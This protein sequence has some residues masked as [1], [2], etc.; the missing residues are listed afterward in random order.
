LKS[1]APSAQDVR[2]IVPDGFLVGRSVHSE[3]EALAVQAEGGCDYLFFGTVFRSASKPDDHRVAGL[4]G[5]R[6]VCAAISLPV[7]AIGGVSPGRVREVTA[8]GAAGI[9]AISLFAEASDIAA[10]TVALRHGVDTSAG[11]RLD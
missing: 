5:L 3:E 4:E 8:A 10:V 9:A 7:I 1:D 11:E 6:R 2:R